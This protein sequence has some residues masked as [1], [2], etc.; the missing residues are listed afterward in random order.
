[1]PVQPIPEG[2]HALTP[3]LV[4]KGAARA[5]AFYEKAFGAEVLFRMDRPDGR[6]GHSELRI[7]DSRFMLADE[8]PEVGAR[9]PE[10]VGGTPVTLFLYD[11]D[12]D[13]T[14]A[15]AAAAGA[16]VTR[17]V[18]N[19]F[20]GDRVGGLTDPFGH[21]WMI[22]THVEDVPPDELARRAARERPA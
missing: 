19:Q 14:V 15:R 9:S 1:M 8:F 12:V 22:A 13:A 10:S 11:G 4:V 5:I 3:Y 18:E 2:Y 7:R 6:V 21:V 20:Y 16:R 17:P